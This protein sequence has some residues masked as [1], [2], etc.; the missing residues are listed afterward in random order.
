LYF[1]DVY[2]NRKSISSEY[3]LLKGGEEIME[4]GLSG[5]DMKN[6]QVHSMV[7]TVNETE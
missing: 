7:R 1:K 3:N 2:T 4:F 6:C 5:E